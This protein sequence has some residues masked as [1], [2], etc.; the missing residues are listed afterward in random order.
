[1]C[2][3]APVLLLSETFL[4]RDRLSFVFFTGSIKRKRQV[5]VRSSSSQQGDTSGKEVRRL[6][7]RLGQGFG[8]LIMLFV[9]TG[10]PLLA[11][12][13]TVGSTW[14]RRLQDLNCACNG[15]FGYLFEKKAL[16][17]GVARLFLSVRW[18][19]AIDLEGNHSRLSKKT[20][21]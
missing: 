4:S 3:V 15:Y 16:W 10:L 17:T 6:W 20:P 1:M 18:N 12:V 19:T 8:L 11:E 21:E 2:A 9:G 7:W 5:S 14:R 13:F